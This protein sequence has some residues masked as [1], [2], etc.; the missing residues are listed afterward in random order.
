[1]GLTARRR[2]SDCGADDH[3]ARDGIELIGAAALTTVV[4]I[5]PLGGGK[6]VIQLAR[7]RIQLYR[8]G[9]VLGQI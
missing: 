6:F 1:M 8:K 4:E 3:I 2:G 9:C 5:S 7:D